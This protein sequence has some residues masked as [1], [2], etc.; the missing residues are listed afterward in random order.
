MSSMASAMDAK[1]SV[2]L[3]RSSTESASPSENLSATRAKS[4]DRIS[5]A[6]V[7]SIGGTA[8]A[9]EWSWPR[10]VV[11]FGKLKRQQSKRYSARGRRRQD[12]AKEGGGTE[13][14][15]PC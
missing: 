14:Q 15:F 4:A 5:G 12:K 9:T 6:T 10:T 11:L 1:P 8:S 2:G 13:Q 7:E 3:S